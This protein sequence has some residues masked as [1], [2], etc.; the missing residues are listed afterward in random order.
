MDERFLLIAIEKAKESVAVGGF[1]AGAIIVKDDKIIGEGISIGNKINDPTAHGESAAIRTA[2]QNLS[3]TDLTGSTLYASMQPCVMCLGAAMW[4]GVSRIVYACDMNKVDE[5][6]YG[7]HYDSFDINSKFTHPLEI[8]HLAELE[9]E[10]LNVVR[11]W[12]KS[13]N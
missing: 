5:G 3:T 7:G 4:S 2:C 8:T 11:D 10:S 12:E 13:L 9:N 6:Y 1:P